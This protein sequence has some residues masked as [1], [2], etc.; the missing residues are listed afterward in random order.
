M[1]LKNGF[2]LREVAGECV[3]VPAEEDLNFNGMITLNATGKLLWSCLE[4][5]TTIE[6]MT[7]A[8]CSEYD[9]DQA[10]AAADATEFADKLKERGF[11]E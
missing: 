2:V 9:I 11:L 8:L 6:E 10:T 1:K 4:K 5:G 7:A 3:V